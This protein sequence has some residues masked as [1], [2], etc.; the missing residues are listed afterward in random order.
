MRSNEPTQ[1]RYSGDALGYWNEHFA[2]GEQDGPQVWNDETP[3]RPVVLSDNDLDI[4]EAALKRQF[5]GKKSGRSEVIHAV[6]AI[7]KA[8]S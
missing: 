1:M 8:R 4:I 2:S 6:L 3:T 7:R 5:V